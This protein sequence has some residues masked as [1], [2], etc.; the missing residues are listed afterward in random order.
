M[1]TW[2][3]GTRAKLVARDIVKTAISMD[4]SETHLGG[5]L[6]D[7]DSVGFSTHVGDTRTKRRGAGNQEES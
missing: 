5:W 2:V 7:G 1:W 4:V 3:G 6:G